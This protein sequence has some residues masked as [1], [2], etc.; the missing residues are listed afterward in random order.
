MSKKYKL[1]I[2][3][4]DGTLLESHRGIISAINKTLIKYN[5]KWPEETFPIKNVIGPPLDKSIQKA[6]PNMS[7]SE[8]KTF[9]NSFREEYS[10]E[11]NIF[12]ASTYPN[13]Y[14]TLQKLKDLGYKL[15]I[16]TFKRDDLTQMLFKHFKFDKYFDF[17]LGIDKNNILTKADL[18]KLAI[19]KEK[20]KGDETV[21]IGDTY[22][23]YLSSTKANV[24]FIAVLFGYGLKK[25]EDLNNIKY[26]KCIE[27]FDKII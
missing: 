15:A 7:E 21:Y 25:Y 14:E 13:E 11:E 10:K 23:D 2:F 4:V 26:V 5:L 19:K 8:V 16:V 6:F 9:V 1:L 22:S 24:S 18:I 3:D 27:S 12:N 20:V 17:A